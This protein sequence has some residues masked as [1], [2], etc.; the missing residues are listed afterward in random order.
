M[1]ESR[2]HNRNKQAT[3]LERSHAAEYGNDSS[4]FFFYLW[5]FYISEWLRTH[6]SEMMCALENCFSAQEKEK[7]E[8]LGLKS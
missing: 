2:V 3:E 4:A 8:I 6:S 1:T 5:D 7:K